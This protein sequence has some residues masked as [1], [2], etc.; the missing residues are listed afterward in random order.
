MT[1]NLFK[2]KIR[3]FDVFCSSGRYYLTHR[4]Q[5]RLV[6]HWICFH[7]RLQYLYFLKHTPGGKFSFCLI[8]RIWCFLLM[9]PHHCKRLKFCFV[10]VIEKRKK[11]RS[12]TIDIWP[13][14]SFFS[15]CLK[16]QFNV[17]ILLFDATYFKYLQN[18]KLTNL[19]SWK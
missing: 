7:R 13:V 12:K 2:N 4:L 15:Y 6:N 14:S 18:F 3:P 9:D 17:S 5:L 10:S 8:N 16:N 19:D 1:S 11:P